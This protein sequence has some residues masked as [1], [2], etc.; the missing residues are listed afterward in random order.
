[1]SAPPGVEEGEDVEAYYGVCTWPFGVEI[2][3][4]EIIQLPRGFRGIRVAAAY[5]SDPIFREVLEHL[6]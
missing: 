2:S 4:E 1:V 3:L 5:H 6:V